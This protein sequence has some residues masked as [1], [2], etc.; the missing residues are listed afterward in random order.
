MLSTLLTP[1][2]HSKMPL[3]CHW[4]RPGAHAYFG[5]GL[6]YW[7]DRL[8]QLTYQA[9]LVFVYNFTTFVNTGELDVIANY[10]YGGEGWGLSTLH[11]ELVMSNGDDHIVFRDPYTFAETRRITVH[12]GAQTVRKI[13]E[14]EV[15]G[16]KICKR[17]QGGRR[18]GSVRARERARNSAS[19]SGF[20]AHAARVLPRG[21]VPLAFF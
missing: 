8:Y 13:N 4:V 10:S 20:R 6:A 2:S 18:A 1:R 14:L 19:S 12:Q 11:N 17:E 7:H 5:E 21:L 16:D 15:V 9:H 3:P